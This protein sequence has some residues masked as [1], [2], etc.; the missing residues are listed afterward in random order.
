VIKKEMAIKNDQPDPAQ[1]VVVPQRLKMVQR[2]LITR[3]LHQL[4]L[5]P[6]RNQI[7]LLMV[8]VMM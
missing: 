8:L 4:L 2:R 5:P 7:S 6:Q 3:T 1:L